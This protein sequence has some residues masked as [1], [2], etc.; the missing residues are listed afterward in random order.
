MGSAVIDNGWTLDVSANAYQVVLQYSEHADDYGFTYDLGVEQA[1]DLAW[2]LRRAAANARDGLYVDRRVDRR[3]P[4]PFAEFG[5]TPL[6][7]GWSLDVFA[8]TEREVVLRCDWHHNGYRY[9]YHMNGVQ[10][11]NL[12]W[13]LGEAADAVSSLRQS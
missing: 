5:S 13:F 1:R 4:A 8:T 6:P 12:G 9:S 2:N 10:G 11:H 7:N 3:Q